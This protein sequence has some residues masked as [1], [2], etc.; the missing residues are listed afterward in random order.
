MSLQNRIREAMEGA[1]LKPQG[2]A[3]ATHRTSGAVTQ[4]LNGSTKTLKADTASMLEAA[5]GYRAGWIVTG[6]GSKAAVAPPFNPTQSLSAEAALIASEFDKVSAGRR[7][8]L[9]ASLTQLIAAAQ[10]ETA[11]KTKPPPSGS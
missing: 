4:W 5:T 7:F 8:A 10:L 11:Q 1:G 9:L 6:R 2:L 3:R